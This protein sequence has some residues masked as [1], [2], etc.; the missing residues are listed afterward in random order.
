MYERVTYMSLAYETHLK[1]VCFN[2]N[3][4]QCCLVVQGTSC[5]SQVL[6]DITNTVVEF[7]F[8]DGCDLRFLVVSAHNGVQYFDMLESHI[9]V[10]YFKIEC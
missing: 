5:I 7:Q 2:F 3:I 10:N 6:A 8:S 1:L 9:F 4:S